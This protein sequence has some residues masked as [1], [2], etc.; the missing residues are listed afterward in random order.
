MRVD[1]RGADGRARAAPASPAAPRPDSQP[2][3][4]WRS[5]S[6]SSAMIR[7]GRSGCPGMSW[8]STASWRSQGGTP[9]PY[10]PCQSSRRDLIVV[11]AGAAGL[12]ASLVAADRGARVT[13]ISARPLAET[14]SYWAQGGL[15]AALAEE[16]SPARH[17]QDTLVAGRDLVRRSAAEVL[18]D[19]APAR[20]VDLERLGVRFDA[21]RPRRPRARPGG[22]SHRAPRRPC[23]RAARPGAGS[24]ASSRPTSSRSRASRCSR[25]AACGRCSPRTGASPASPPTTA[26]RS[27]PAR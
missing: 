3:Q 22:R 21:D 9:V 16:D 12:F 1:V 2:N 14:A 6:A 18:C 7:A 25:T 24:C 26:A 5:I 13:L 27:R 23:R 20:F 10:P 17:L 8:A 15:A 4:S 19:E 11:G